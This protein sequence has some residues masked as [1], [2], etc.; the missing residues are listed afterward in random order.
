[1]KNKSEKSVF[2]Y[3]YYYI[4]GR[5]ICNFFKMLPDAVTDLPA[6]KSGP[7]WAIVN[8]WTGS[9]VLAAAPN[10]SATCIPLWKIPDKALSLAFSLSMP[11]RG[12]MRPQF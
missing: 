8:I 1:M 3:M 6:A 12:R 9:R 7:F 10:L 2:L 5:Q 11:R 4:H